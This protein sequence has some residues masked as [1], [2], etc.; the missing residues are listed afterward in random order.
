[1]QS[2]HSHCPISRARTAPFFL[3]PLLI[4]NAQCCERITSLALCS[5]HILCTLC[6]WESVCV[7]LPHMCAELAS[8][9]LIY[10]CFIHVSRPSDPL[11]GKKYEA[12]A[13]WCSFVACCVLCVLHSTFANKTGVGF[14]DFK[15][16][17]NYFSLCS[18]CWEEYKKMLWKN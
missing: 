15:G 17:I 8:R 14:S 7:D 9:V 11:G 4:A 6:R 10:L 16:I 2:A 18:V 3:L 1:M 12:R 5:S 13:I